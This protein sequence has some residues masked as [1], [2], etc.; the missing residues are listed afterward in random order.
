MR[1]GKWVDVPNLLG[2]RYTIHGIIEGRVPCHIK[3]ESAV[4]P[5]AWPDEPTTQIVEDQCNREFDLK[6]REAEHM[7]EALELKARTEAGGSEVDFSV[8]QE[9]DVWWAV[10]KV[11]GKVLYR[12]QGQDP[13][14]AA[15]KV[16]EKVALYGLE[17]P[18]ETPPDGDS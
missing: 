12:E 2:R 13:K 8:T 5:Y 6:I 14:D 10:A 9:D 7:A 15:A 17:G 11:N 3:V 16:A 1:E 18:Q 4:I